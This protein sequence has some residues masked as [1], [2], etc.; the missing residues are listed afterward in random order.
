M[1]LNFE[2]KTGEVQ[3]VTGGFVAGFDP[4]RNLNGRP[5]KSFAEIAANL[6]EQRK[7]TIID[8][9]ATRAENGDVR[10]FEA[11]RD[12]AEGRPAQRV[13]VT[14]T[15]V[16]DALRGEI[17]QA[18]AAAGAIKVIEGEYQEIENPS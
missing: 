14:D 18:L 7:T 5:R 11:L 6:P 12:T 4:R 17:L 16:A 9:I 13:E 15:T 2:E 1:T 8:T 3:T 10:A